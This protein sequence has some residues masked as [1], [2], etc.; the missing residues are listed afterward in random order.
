MKSINAHLNFKEKVNSKNIKFHLSNQTNSNKDKVYVINKKSENDKLSLNL[1]IENLFFKGSSINSY[2]INFKPIKCNNNPLSPFTNKIP[3][4]SNNKISNK[5]TKESTS[6]TTI[7][8]HGKIK[9]TKSPENVKFNLLLKYEKEELTTLNTEVI[10]NTSQSNIFKNN[11]KSCLYKDNKNKSIDF[12]FNK[13]YTQTE[14]NF[15]F[16]TNLTRSILNNSS[17]KPILKETS[18]RNT[19]NFDEEFE[20]RLLPIEEYYKIKFK[21]TITNKDDIITKEN[22]LNKL[23]L[24]NLKLVNQNKQVILKNFPKLKSPK[25]LNKK[26]S[27]VN[28]IT[29]FSELLTGNINTKISSLF[30]ESKTSKKVILN[31]GE[32]PNKKK[33][34]NKIK[35]S[36]TIQTIDNVKEDKFG[37]IRQNLRLV[38]QNNLNIKIDDKSKEKLFSKEKLNRLE[39]LYK[40]KKKTKTRNKQ[41]S[42]IDLFSIKHNSI[43][44]GCYSGKN[45][46]QHI[47]NKKYSDN[48]FS[49]FDY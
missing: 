26:N 9:K 23:N 5:E 33:K 29:S 17:V 1:K 22:T 25:I 32:S 16:N 41:T 35:Y 24:L 45:L 40:K 34:I 28:S 18:P 20:D 31:N 38:T 37:K 6:P 14:S 13:D 48:K 10:N 27:K 47:L 19:N 3:S 7:S 42:L 43:M 44:S 21:K 30:K 39:G 36:K 4:K 2:N 11:I 49:T 12:Q 8:S 46:A 15:N